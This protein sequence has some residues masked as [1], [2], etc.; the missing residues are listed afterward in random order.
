MRRFFAPNLRSNS[1]VTG[2]LSAQHP[3]KSNPAGRHVAINVIT[4]AQ[5]YDTVARRVGLV[6]FQFV[7]RD[8]Y[9]CSD[10]DVFSPERS[11]G[12]GVR[13]DGDITIAIDLERVRP[14][15]IRFAATG[16]SG[17]IRLHQRLV[18]LAKLRISPFPLPVISGARYADQKT[19]RCTKDEAFH[20]ALLS[21]SS[22]F[23]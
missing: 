23:V 6:I 8:D 20:A 21:F 18:P 3:N 1:D 16:N 2:R 14:V 12:P 19:E 4:A 13:D 7:I 22:Q 17:I 11:V 15:G 10:V 5:K 9:L